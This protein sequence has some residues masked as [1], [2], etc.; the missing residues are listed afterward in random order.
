MVNEA[1]KQELIAVRFSQA[2]QRRRSP[3]STKRK[4]RLSANDRETNEDVDDVKQVIK[5]AKDKLGVKIK[6]TEFK[7]HR[8]GKKRSNKTRNAVVSFKDKQT[9]ENI[10]TQRKKLIKPENQVESIYTGQVSTPPVL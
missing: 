7:M 9:R 8:L 6:T 10:Y 1:L 2:A 4:S 5:L 3:V